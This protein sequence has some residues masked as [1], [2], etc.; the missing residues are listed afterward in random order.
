ME[1]DSTGSPSPS[2]PAGASNTNQPTIQTPTDN[3]PATSQPPATEQKKQKALLI[4][5]IICAILAVDGVAF[6][7]YGMFFHQEPTCEAECTESTSDI[8]NN[9]EQDTST[10]EEIEITDTYVLRDLD[11]K[12]ALIHHTSQLDSMLSFGGTHS[13]YMLYKNGT[14]NDTA[15]LTNT[16]EYLGNFLRTPTA[17]ET[18]TIA[19]DYNLSENDKLFLYKVIDADIADAKYYDTFGEKPV[20][21]TEIDRSTCGIYTYDQALNVYFTFSGCGGTSP[22]AS[23]YFKTKYTKDSNHAYVYV[24]TAVINHETRQIYCDAGTFETE[25]AE[26]CE[27]DTSSDNSAQLTEDD[28]NRDSLATYRLVFNKAD[29]GTYYFTKVEKL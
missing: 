25:N 4:T 14:L 26:T 28:I 22:I 17:M 13:E 2:A 3:P 27:K 9:V 20:R 21:N 18:D 8:P 24:Q 11:E 10:D 23:F 19:A 5:T 6:G 7:I 29:N 1:Q 15:K 12:T 16:I